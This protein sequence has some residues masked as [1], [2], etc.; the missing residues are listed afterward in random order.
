MQMIF[1]ELNFESLH[2]VFQFYAFPTAIKAAAE[3]IS[4][5]V[6]NTR[7]LLP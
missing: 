6:E 1:N 3:I 2:N 4:L 5:K 7:S